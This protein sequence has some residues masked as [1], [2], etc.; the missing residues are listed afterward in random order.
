AALRTFLHPAIGRPPLAVYFHESQLTYPDSPQMTGDLSYAFLNWTSALA[1]DAVYFNSGY[2][3]DVFFAEAPRLL[4]RMPDHP[5]LGLLPEVAGKAKVLPVGVDL[6]WAAAQPSRTATPVLLWNHR[7]EHDKDP[8]TFADGVRAVAET[9]DFDLALLGERFH[10][11]PGALDELATDLADRLIAN[12]H[13]PSDEYRSL[14]LR[15][16]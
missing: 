14:L 8:E 16:D 7:W 13:L 11:V 2:H 15:S 10:T 4:K 1:A 9:H 5:H 3:R 6:D 12:G